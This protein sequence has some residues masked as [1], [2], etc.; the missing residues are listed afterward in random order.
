M[1][2]LIISKFQDKILNCIF[3]SLVPNLTNSFLQYFGLQIKRP[4]NTFV[5][6]ECQNLYTSGAKNHSLSSEKQLS[7]YFKNTL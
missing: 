2:L 5:P 4:K 1:V 6:S 3:F 7:T